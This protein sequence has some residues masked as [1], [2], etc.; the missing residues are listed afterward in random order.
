[1]SEEQ[2][3]W[4]RERK[5]KEEERHLVPSKHNSHDCSGLVGKYWMKGGSITL[6]THTHTHTHA[7][8]HMHT[9]G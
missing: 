6:S 3:K 2:E 8:T 7:H 1:M 9:E 5:D 4:E